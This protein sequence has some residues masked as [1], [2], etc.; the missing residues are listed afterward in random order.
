M[1]LTECWGLLELEAGV[2]QCWKRTRFLAGAGHALSSWAPLQLPLVSFSTSEPLFTGGFLSSC[3]L[4]GSFVTSHCDPELAEGQQPWAARR[5]CLM[6][7]KLDEDSIRKGWAGL[8]WVWLGWVGLGGAGLGWVGLGG[9]GLGLG[10][11]V[12]G[13]Q[14]VLAWKAQWQE[15]QAVAGHSTSGVSKQKWIPVLS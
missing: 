7:Q 2:G 11:F 5:W 4:W 3:L 15:P 13:I 10:C 1:E 9:A 8:G 14:P 12:W 6:L